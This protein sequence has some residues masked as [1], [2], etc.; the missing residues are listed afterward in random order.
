M[1]NVFVI[2]MQGTMWTPHGKYRHFLWPIQ[3]YRYSGQ[4][5]LLGRDANI[6][7]HLRIDWLQLQGI[8]VDTEQCMRRI[9]NTILVK[10]TICRHIN[11]IDQVEI[12]THQTYAPDVVNAI[13]AVA[14][15]RT[16]ASTA[17]TAVVT[18]TDVGIGIL[19]RISSKNRAWNIAVSASKLIYSKS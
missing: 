10:T 15:E 3:T 17:A 1:D 14:P 18:V 12:R 11:T 13:I 19:R 5:K 6:L 7:K 8:W 4:G 2:R 9:C 16:D